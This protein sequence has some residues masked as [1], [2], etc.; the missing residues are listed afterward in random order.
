MLHGCIARFTEAL[1]SCRGR[2]FVKLEVK[3]LFA[4]FTRDRATIVKM[5]RL[6]VTMT[7]HL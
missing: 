3:L 1:L 4:H 6:I 7:S 2:Y 5:M